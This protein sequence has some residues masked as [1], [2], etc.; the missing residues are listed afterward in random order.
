MQPEYS[1]Y[2]HGF[3][4]RDYLPHLKVAGAAYFVTF[5]LADSLPKEVLLRIKTEL[6]Q[7]VFPEDATLDERT[8]HLRQL[9]RRKIEHSLD[10]GAGQCWLRHPEMASLLAG[11]LKHFDGERY[12]LR[13]WVIMPNHVHV[14]VAPLKEFSLGA[15]VK[16]W[17]Q[18]L[19]TRAKKIL[20]IPPG[21]FWQPE[22]YDHWTR[23]ADERERVISYIHQNPVKAK[24]CQRP[25]ECP[26]SSAYPVQTDS[27][28]PGRLEACAT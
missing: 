26:W 5:R 17:K 13:A 27:I 3:H 4:R 20:A 2:I 15:I 19:A 12:K 16:S 11:A 28:N 23:D 14:L 10:Q 9:R 22:S 24:L 7:T 21:R 8:E 1:K 18:F 6:E 25:E